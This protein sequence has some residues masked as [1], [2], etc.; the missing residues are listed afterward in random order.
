MNKKQKW[1]LR[2]SIGINMIFLIIFLLKYTAYSYK[3]G[4]L[5][6]DVKVGI[7][8]KKDSVF[9]TLPKGLTVRDVSERGISAIDL[10]ENHRFDIIITSDDN[11]LVDYS[12]SKEEL[13]PFGNLYSADSFK[14]K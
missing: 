10:F 4:V 9:F 6:K 2:I 13:L 11:D 3:L 12:K 7:F 5:K 14:Y 1:I 8:D